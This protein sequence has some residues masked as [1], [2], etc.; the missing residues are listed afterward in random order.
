MM[1]LKRKMTKYEI[2]LDTIDQR[3]ARGLNFLENEGCNDEEGSLVDNVLEVAKRR[4][5]PS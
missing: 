4:R 1:M 5:I 3:V 2:A